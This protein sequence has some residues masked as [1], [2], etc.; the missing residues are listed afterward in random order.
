MTKIGLS[1]RECQQIFIALVAYRN[2]F[3]SLPMPVVDMMIEKFKTIVEQNNTNNN[4]R[5]G[6]SNL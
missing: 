2:I 5:E 1:P 4:E 6:N 3:R